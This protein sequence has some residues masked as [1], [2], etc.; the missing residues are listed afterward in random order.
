MPAKHQVSE[1]LLWRH[2]PAL[3][4]ADIYRNTKENTNIIQT[5]YLPIKDRKIY[6]WYIRLI[7]K[8]NH[9]QSTTASSYMKSEWPIITLGFEQC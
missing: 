9:K 7:Q 1:M 5:V 3:S 4:T 6:Y 2:R 8:H